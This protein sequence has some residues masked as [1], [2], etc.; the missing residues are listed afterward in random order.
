[1]DTSFLKKMRYFNEID[2]VSLLESSGAILASWGPSNARLLFCG[3]EPRALAF[4][5]NGYKFQGTV[6]LSVNG[7][8]YYEVRFYHGD[9]LVEMI[10]DIFV[11]DLVSIIDEYVEKQPEYVR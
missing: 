11:D 4:D 8:D 10:G 3:K 6:V 5:V 9:T 7:A 2:A 1:M